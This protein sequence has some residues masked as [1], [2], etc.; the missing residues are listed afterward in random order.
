MMDASETSAGE[1]LLRS[2]EVA[3]LAVLIAGDVRLHLQSVMQG[4]FGIAGAQAVATPFNP[5]PS[6]QMCLR[7]APPGLAKVPETLGQTLRAV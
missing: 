7:F 4:P 5:N 3:R 1:Q 6:P 2:D